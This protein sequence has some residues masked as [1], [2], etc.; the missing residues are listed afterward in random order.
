MLQHNADI[1]VRI[2]RY[3]LRRLIQIP[4]LFCSVQ[5]LFPGLLTYPRPVIECQR[6]C[7]DR[8]FK[9][10]RNI[11]HC[12]TFSSHNFRPLPFIFCLINQSIFHLIYYYLT[13]KRPAV[14]YGAV[15]SIAEK[16]SSRRISALQIL[17]S[18]A[19]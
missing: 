7:I 8:K 11:L 12:H 1:F 14:Q 10:F 17:S 15:Y 5:Y 13:I 2:G 6:H 4:H 9:F 16:M 19:P 3:I 18:A